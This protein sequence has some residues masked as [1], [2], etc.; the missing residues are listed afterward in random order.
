SGTPLNEDVGTISIK[1]TATDGSGEPISDTFD[2]AVGNTNDAPTVANLIPNQPATE[3][4]AFSFQFAADTFADVDVGDTLTY[5]ATLADGS[6]LPSW[7]SFDP[8]TRTFS[9]TPLNEDVGT[10]SIKVTATD[11]SG[12]PISDTFD[13][14]VGNTNDAPTEITLIGASVAEFAARGTTVGSLST[15]DQDDTSGFTYALV[16]DAGGRFSVDGALLLV[17]NGV[18][19]D[20]EQTASHTVTVRSSDAG[21]LHVDRSFTITVNDV[22]PEFVVGTAV[23]ETIVGGALSD[24]LFGGGGNDTLDGGAGNDI[25][26]G[27]DGRDVLI[28]G[29][30]SDRYFT[31]GGDKIVEAVNSGL[32]TVVSTAS[33]TLAANVE[34]LV[35]SGAAKISGTGNAL[36]N[37]IDGS[38]NSAANMLAGRGGNDVYVVGAGDRI[39]E[40][41]NGGTDT[42]LSSQVSL[43]LGVFANV[44]NAR[45]LGNAALNVAGNALNNVIFG[46]DAKNTISGGAG[47]DFINGGLGNDILV[48]GAGNDF[49]NGGLGNDILVGGAGNDA[50]VFNTTLSAAT[51]VDT[52]FMYNTFQDNIR[53]DNAVFTALGGTG[54]LSGSNFWSAANGLAHDA[55][56]RIIYNT[57]TG[58]LSYDADG[59]G[60]A[61]AVA[62][63][64]IGN[65]PWLTA[66]EF[67]VI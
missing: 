51:N 66:S 12:E 26:N 18:A 40:A 1:V 33:H 52:I 6:A 57:S 54:V 38:T 46:N 64:V 9:G 24:R 16:D 23:G 34:N 21:G 4:A 56:D 15:S 45:L 55:D 65:K 7:L 29:S 35:L 44:E 37:R 13:L 31:D 48:G 10:I 8:S 19:L 25:L 42:V 53:L 30:G 2:L 50:F 20:F 58:V 5:A 28:G 3:D 61:A 59:N 67:F 62:F 14:A 63:A 39:T 60:K 36:A 32:D 11:G 43:N 17:A 47:N 22:N 41:A 27:G 49:I